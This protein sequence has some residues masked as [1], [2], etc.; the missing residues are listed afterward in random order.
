MCRASKI[1]FVSKTN[2]IIFVCIFFLSGCG[3][4]AIINRAAFDPVTTRADAV[5]IIPAGVQEI[6]IESD[7]RVR[8]QCFFVPY[9][10]SSGLIVYFHGNAGNIFARLPE[11]QNLSKTGISVL[12]VGYRGYGKSTGKPSEEGIYRDGRAAVKY[13]TEN[14][15]Y[16]A[17]KIFLCGRSLGSVVALETARN[18][19]FAGLILVSP[20]ASGADILRA[21]GYRVAPLLV[22]DVI[23]N[24]KKLA[25]IV[26]PVLII[27]GDKD[28]V[29]PWTMGK[30]IYLML[31]VS[32]KIVTI[33][34]GAH[35]DLEFIDH[36]LYHG[37]IAQFIREQGVR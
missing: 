18:K 6:Y 32:K 2:Y 24:M 37:A 30:K 3:G 35:S 22:G 31:S 4:E 20:L 23:D 13:A 21:H 11:L 33:R 34:G 8:L 17:D 15:G 26:S 9:G 19:N 25:E 27:H 14:L 29:V 1:C 5:Q 7:D 10:A 28:E 36:Q 16:S 12:G